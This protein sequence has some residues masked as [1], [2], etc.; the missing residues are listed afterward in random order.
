[1]DKEKRKKK[2]KTDWLTSWI[3]EAVVCADQSELRVFCSSSGKTQVSRMQQRCHFV[4][5]PL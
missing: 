5:D 3:L 4:G 2:K 1:M